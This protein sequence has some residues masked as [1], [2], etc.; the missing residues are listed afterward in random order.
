MNTPHFALYFTPEHLAAARAGAASPPLAEAWDALRERQPMHALDFA[1]RALF[2]DEPASA[3]Q[4]LGA[5]L[6]QAN[7]A[8]HPPRYVE[9]AA[10]FVAH[11]QAFE[12]LRGLPGLEPSELNHWLAYAADAGQALLHDAPLAPHEALWRN[13]ARLALAIV[14]DQPDQAQAS[15]EEFRRVIREDVRPQGFM[16]KVVAGEDGG[17]LFRQIEATAALVLTA[18]AGQTAG[19]GLWDYELRGVS[20]LTAALLPHYYFYDTAKW[21][22]DRGVPADEVQAVFHRFGGYLEI[23]NRRAPNK[24]IQIVLEDLRPLNTP[25]AGGQTTLSHGLV[26]KKRRGLFG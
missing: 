5:L 11:L 24:D 13:L 6:R 26:E 12:M 10:A 25:W 7:A 9:A 18:E 14:L 23:V 2:L 17:S 15:A 22:W 20:A 19:L 1:F 4:A 21:K 3:Q 16:S 8:D